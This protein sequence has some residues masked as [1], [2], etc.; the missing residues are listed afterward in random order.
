MYFGVYFGVRRGFVFVWGTYDRKIFYL[1]GNFNFAK[2]YFSRL[3]EKTLENKHKIDVSQVILTLQGNSC[4]AS[5]K[6]K[7][8]LFYVKIKG[9]VFS[10]LIDEVRPPVPCSPFQPPNLFLPGE[11]SQATTPPP[12]PSHRAR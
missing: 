2:G 11:C 6:V 12:P 5:R 9:V 8:T 1:A 4:L 10:T 7:I 3:S